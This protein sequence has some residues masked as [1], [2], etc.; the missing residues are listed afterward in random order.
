MS[1]KNSRSSDRHRTRAGLKR[2]SQKQ[3]AARPDDAGPSVPRL[4]R[5]IR[6]LKKKLWATRRKQPWQ[7]PKQPKEYKCVLLYDGT[8]EGLRKTA[9]KVI[10]LAPD[11]TARHVFKILPCRVPEQGA[12]NIPIRKTG[13]TPG[14]TTELRPG[15]RVEWLPGRRVLCFGSQKEI[16]IYPPERGRPGADELAEAAWLLYREIKAANPG[17]RKPWQCV[18]EELDEQRPGETTIA[19][20]AERLR[21]LVN[22]WLARRK[23]AR[24][25]PPPP[26]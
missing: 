3:S 26:K 8:C 13:S 4:P 19:E 9:R 10:R 12:T 11:L 7:K 24:L 5:G 21:C 22:G 23:E 18:A 20:A 15:L 14:T 25:T 17:E 2:K 6:T 1:K 16:L